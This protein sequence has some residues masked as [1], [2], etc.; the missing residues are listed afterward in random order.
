VSKLTIIKEVSKRILPCGQKQRRILVKCICGSKK[1][2]LFRNFRSGNT[3]SCGCLRKVTGK[4]NGLANTLHGESRKTSEYFCWQNMM[5]RCYNNKNPIYSYYGGRGI[6]VCKRWD[7]Y[8]NFLGDLG[9]KP[10]KDYS[11]DRVN[12]SGNYEPSNCRWATKSEQL[13]NRR[14]C[15]KGELCH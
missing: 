1:V 13:K 15:T 6:K 14:K 9:R 2:I 8:S 11:I 3:K 4:K 5:Q 7:K 10:R 12:N